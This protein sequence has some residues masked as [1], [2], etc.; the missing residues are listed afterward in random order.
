[1]KRR[2]TAA[3]KAATTRMLAANKR[4]HRNPSKT[5][6][7]K[8]RYRNPAPVARRRRSTHR[9]PGFLGFKDSGVLKE[10]LSMDGALMIGAAFAA[11][12]AVDWVQEKLMP[13]A[14]GWTKIGVKAAALLAGA[15]AI[16]KFGKKPKAALAFG[17]TGAA[18][19]VADAYN[20]W[21]TPSTG[22]S[23]LGADALAMQPGAVQALAWNGYRPGL[24]ESPSY[25]MG[26]A[27]AP[28]AFARSFR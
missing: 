27:A 5:Y 20:L 12:L 25:R 4:R 28:S 22:T 10:I 16:Q 13:S 7:A 3:Q 15:W 11:P 18:V 21:Q 23:G 24:S 1:M 14:T 2:R 17:V 6:K 26:L 8:R 19:L 9:N